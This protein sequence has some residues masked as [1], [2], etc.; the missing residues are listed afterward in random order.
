MSGRHAWIVIDL[1]F[2]DAGKGTVTDFLA[3]D[4]D[5]GLVVRFNGGAQA[6]HNVVAP[7]GRHHTFSQFGAASFVPGVQTLL[8]PGFLLHPWGMAVEADHLAVA[9][10]TD[11]WSRTAVD[12]RARVI[13]PYQQAT[14]RIREQLRGSDAHGT[15]GVGIGECA[16]DALAHPGDA[17]HAGDLGDPDRLRARLRAQRDRK[18]SE[19]RALPGADRLPD[20]D[21][22]SDE[23]LIDRVIAAWGDV[24]ARLWCTSAAETDALL[25][26]E[27]RVI[28]EGAQGVLL[29]EDWGFH[30]HTTWS[31]CTPRDALQL[32]DDRPVTRL[33]VTRIATVR[34]G[35]GPLP[36]FDPGLTAALPE[37]HNGAD[38]WQGAFRVGA[39][40]AVLLRYAIAA[41][42]GLDGIALT[43]LDRCPSP[44]PVCNQYAD[45]TTDLPLG[46]PG[47][48][49]HTA[50]LCRRLLSARPTIE[51]TDDIIDFVE[52]AT[53][54]P[55]V[56]TSHG[57]RAGDKRWRGRPRG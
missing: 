6:G 52:D 31:R 11:A 16:A 26:R 17:L 3:R 25:R 50:Q 24:A 39:L 47:D 15:C 30:P 57:P 9:G 43:W 45:G 29:D 38:G 53:R 27:P 28:F 12:A 13:T 33:G 41:C 46:R 18:W 34:H 54:L 10:V 20:H 23:A 1:G 44:V 5:A 19:V 21:L 55:V 56:L 36:T 49:T 35:A 37:P 40:D 4:R 51:H 32:L 42:R 7:D 2:G 8:G 14:N 22:F 48:L